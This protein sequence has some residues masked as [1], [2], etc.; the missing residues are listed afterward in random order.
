VN[1]DFEYPTSGEYVKLGPGVELNFISEQDSNALT[2][3]LKRPVNCWDPLIWEEQDYKRNWGDAAVMSPYFEVLR[4]PT[5]EYS[6]SAEYVILCPTFLRR[7]L[8]I[9]QGQSWGSY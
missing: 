3:K 9:Y 5:S 7:P 6:Q 1:I 8:R 4:K 2:R